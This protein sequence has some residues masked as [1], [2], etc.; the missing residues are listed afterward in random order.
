M[1]ANAWRESLAAALERMG[2]RLEHGS[3]VTT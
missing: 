1:Q 3:F 2:S